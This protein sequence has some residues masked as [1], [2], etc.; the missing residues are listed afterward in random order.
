MPGTQTVLSE[1]RVAPL[2]SM[3]TR[4]LSVSSS[5]NLLKHSTVYGKY[6]G[7]MNMCNEWINHHS[8]LSD[9]LNLLLYYSLCLFGLKVLG[10]S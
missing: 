5:T 2:G 1:N 10:T 9:S 3:R 7:L 6:W 4:V 8:I